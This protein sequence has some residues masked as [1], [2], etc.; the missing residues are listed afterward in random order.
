MATATVDEL[1]YISFPISKWDKTDDGDLIVYGKAT[2]G[3]L[4]S[5][6][7]VVDP[8]WSAK[9]LSDWHGKD[10]GNVRVQH[11]ALRDPAGRSL[12]IEVD[13][14]GDG[15]HWV[16]SL[17]VEPVAKRL[18]EKGVLTA[19]SVGIARPVIKRDPTGKA[20]GG[21]VAGGHLAEISLVDRPANK[22]CGF[23]LG[24][25]DSDGDLELTGEL[26][27]DEE[28]L[29]KFAADEDL[30]VKGSGDAG[31]GDGDATADEDD[32]DEDSDADDGSGDS[33]GD[34]DDGQSDD[35]AVSKA[36][37]ATRLAYKAARAEWLQQEPSI[38]GIAGGTEYLAK[39]A[40]WMRWH[41]HGE[42]EGL[43]GTR[44]AAEM[45]L[46][47]RDFSADQRR[48]AA[49]SGAAMPDGSFPI[50]N[51]EDLGLSLIHI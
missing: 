10:G 13:K 34:E 43:T 42:A 35:T 4:D 15:G 1:T 27:G 22:A 2:D 29:A 5:D 46:A 23:V 47:K 17:V 36:D 24:K 32:G 9:A 49:S 25:S 39:R 11:Q 12:S 20:R 14:D 21:I 28:F 48:D 41:G 19:Y 7:Q 6:D 45:W 51:R 44:E 31:D 30:L 37:G 38:K 50:K 16:K 33:D 18:V 8:S 40:D 26:E 3:S